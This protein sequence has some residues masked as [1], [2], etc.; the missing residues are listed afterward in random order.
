MGSTHAADK[1]EPA[2]TAPTSNS[3]ESAMRVYVDPETGKYS[4][5][6]ITEEQRAQ[7]KREAEAATKQAPQFVGRRL[8]D[9]SYMV[10]FG[11]D[12][13]M[14]STMTVDEHGNTHMNCTQE[15]PDHSHE[16]HSAK[17]E[18]ESK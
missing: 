10:E 14:H 16:S 2:N 8:P 4:P 11:E 17:S 12:M 13:M 7:A 18:A 3:T 1:T 6:P 9:G 15:H 5:T